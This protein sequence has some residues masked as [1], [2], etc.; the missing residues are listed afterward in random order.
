M[1]RPPQRRPVPEHLYTGTS[2]AFEPGDVVQPSRNLP[3]EQRVGGGV[4]GDTSWAWATAH[5][6][7]AHSYAKSAEENTG[8]PGRVFKVEP[9]NPADVNVIPGTHSRGGDRNRLFGHP[10]TRAA[11][12]TGFRVL[13]EVQMPPDNPEINARLERKQSAANRG[14]SFRRQRKEL[15]RSKRPKVKSSPELDASIREIVDLL[16]R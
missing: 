12:E 3:Q 7:T 8:R 13:N 15:E 16:S 11:S 9:I 1:P 5:L 6:D 2:H 10:H 14:A 4:G